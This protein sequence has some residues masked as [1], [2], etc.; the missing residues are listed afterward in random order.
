MIQLKILEG[1]HDTVLDLLA[2]LVLARPVNRL[3]VRR[4][5]DMLPESYSDLKASLQA[6][7]E[8]LPA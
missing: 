7:L 2:E 3:V 6:Y 5:A 8:T 1:D 4:L